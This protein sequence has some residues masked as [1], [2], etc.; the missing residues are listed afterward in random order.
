MPPPARLSVLVTAAVLTLAT[1]SAQKQQSH[2]ATSIASWPLSPAV[3]VTRITRS[4]ATLPPHRPPSPPP[5]G[6]VTLVLL[7]LWRGEPGWFLNRG[8]SA[9]RGGGDSSGR[10]NVQLEQGGQ[11]LELTLDSER[12]V[13]TIA[14]KEV[15][16]GSANVV[17]VDRVDVPGGPIVSSTGSVDPVID[18]APSELYAVF[19]GA[20]DLIPFLRCE[21]RLPQTATLAGNADPARAFAFMQQV[22]DAN[23]ARIIGK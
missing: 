22:L 8:H 3:M 23:C 5:S 2:E 20:P 1:A 21:A 18:A 14:G 6:P 9:E 4:E 7:V 13:V 11:N 17:L 12:R 10:V 16:L 15:A 19:R